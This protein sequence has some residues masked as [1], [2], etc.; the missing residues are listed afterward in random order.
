[1]K[2]LLLLAVLL[3]GCENAP[4]QPV[5][6]DPVK[7]RSTAYEQ[8][9]EREPESTLCVNDLSITNSNL[10]EQW[11]RVCAQDNTLTYCRYLAGKCGG[12]VKLE[13]ETPTQP[14][15]QSELPDTSSAIQGKPVR[16]RAQALHEMCTRDYNPDLCPPAYAPKEK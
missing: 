14:E 8:M 1:M 5:Q 9:C 13:V 6:G 2:Y 15:P 16:I 4:D 7:L 10:N 11:C 12:R 3:T